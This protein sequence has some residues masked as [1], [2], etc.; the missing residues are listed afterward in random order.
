MSRSLG[1]SGRCKASFC[2]GPGEIAE[3]ASHG[4]KLR[5]I[6]K[7]DETMCFPFYMDCII[8]IRA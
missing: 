5:M 6:K 4:V 3:A 8:M 2:G 7:Y 1:N